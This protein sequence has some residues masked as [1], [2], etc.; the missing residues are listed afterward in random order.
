MAVNFGLDLQMTL[1]YK[2]SLNYVTINVFK[3]V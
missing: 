1:K 2:I 3:L